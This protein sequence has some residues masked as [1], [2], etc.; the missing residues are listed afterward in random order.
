MGSVAAQLFSGLSRGFKCGLWLG[1]SK[2]FRDLFPKAR[3]HCLDCV[4][5][6][7]VLLAGEPSHHSKVLST[8]EQAFIKDLSVLC[9]VHLSR[10]DDARFPPDVTLGF[11]AKGF[12][13]GLIRPENLVSRGLSP[14]GTFWQ[15]PSRLSCAFY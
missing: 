5:R 7:F 13:L 10:M 6:V 3:L 2:T 9:S 12:N 4:L 15:T 14:L 11:Q 1:H 8:L